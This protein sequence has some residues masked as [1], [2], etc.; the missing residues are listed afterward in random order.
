[1]VRK[2]KLKT[3]AKGRKRFA[4]WL[5]PATLRTLDALARATGRNRSDVIE[6]AVEA[7]LGRKSTP[8]Q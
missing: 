8:A 2:A 6:D 5:P 1:V 7:A 3:T 4:A